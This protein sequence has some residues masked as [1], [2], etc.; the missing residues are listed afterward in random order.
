MYYVELYAIH[1]Y[2]LLEVQSLCDSKKQ[3]ELPE[4]K[5]LWYKSSLHIFFFHGC[6]D[7]TSAQNSNILC[8]VKT[9]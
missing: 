4:P 5:Q 7:V 2:L 3:Q 8:S 6:Q 1:I 9:I